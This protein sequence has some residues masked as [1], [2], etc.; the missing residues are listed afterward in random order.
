MMD[1]VAKLMILLS[2]TLRMEFWHSTPLGPTQ[3]FAVLV[4]NVFAE[5]MTSAPKLLVEKARV[6]VMMMKNVKTHLFVD[7]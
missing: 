4:T 3:A 1:I 7:T 2:A 6:T 5:K